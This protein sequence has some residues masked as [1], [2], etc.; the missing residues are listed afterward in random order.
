MPAVNI[1]LSE[2]LSKLPKAQAVTVEQLEIV[3]GVVNTNAHLFV[4]E[5]NAVKKRLNKMEESVHGVLQLQAQTNEHINMVC[6]IQETLNEE[7]LK[8]DKDMDE[9]YLDINNIAYKAGDSRLGK[10]HVYGRASK[11]SEYGKQVPY[12]FVFQNVNM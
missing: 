10:T 1:G 6:N 5:M 9:L 11:K 2:E 12:E 8:I 3:I 7:I 4:N